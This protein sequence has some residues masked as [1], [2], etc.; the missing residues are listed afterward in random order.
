VA[1]LN[2]K[3]DNAQPVWTFHQYPFIATCA[4]STRGDEY[5]LY[6]G[7]DDGSIYKMD[8]G[9]SDDGASVDWEYQTPYMAIG[10]FSALKYFR[11]LHVGAAVIAPFDP[12]S[13]RITDR[14][15][16]VRDF[17]VET[18]TDEPSSPFNQHIAVSAT[19]SS[20]TRPL[21]IPISSTGRA[22][23]LVFKGTKEFDYISEPIAIPYAIINFG[24][25]RQR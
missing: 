1:D 9:W 3:T 8:T 20:D 12:L 16:Y 15:H 13:D 21:R 5:G 14:S 11:T 7:T 4:F 2:K 25:P 17:D 10:G 19:L 24:T 23:K 22:L 18:R 6:V